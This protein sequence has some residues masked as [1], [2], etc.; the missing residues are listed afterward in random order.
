MA[1][2]LP[3]VRTQ[4]PVGFRAQVSRDDTLA[5]Q[6]LIRAYY[7]TQT[8]AQVSPDFVS[9]ELSLSKRV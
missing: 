9:P 6:G 1:E 4:Q 3:L 7:R 5:E 2:D 8:I